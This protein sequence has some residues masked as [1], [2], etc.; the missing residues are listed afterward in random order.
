MSLPDFMSTFEAREAARRMLQLTEETDPSVSL[1]GLVIL[2][3]SWEVDSPVETDVAAVLARLPELVERSQGA[4]HSLLRLRAA[5]VTVAME[6]G[7]SAQVALATLNQACQLSDE[8]FHG[9]WTFRELYVRTQGLLLRSPGIG[10]YLGGAMNNLKRSATDSSVLLQGSTCEVPGPI[11]V[12]A[13]R[14]PGLSASAIVGPTLRLFEP[15]EAG[16][17]LQRM[18][19]EE[20]SPSLKKLLSRMGRESAARA[21]TPVPSLD[22]LDEMAKRFPHFDAVLH[23]VRL[24]LALS[25]LGVPHGSV[26]IPPILLRG[27]PGAGKS[28]FAQELARALGCHYEER[29]L[30]VTSEAFVFTGVDSTWKNAKAGLVFDVLFHGPSANPLIC[31]NEVDKTKTSGSNNSPLASLY[32]LLEPAN[33]R[34]FKDEFIGVSIDASKIVWVLTAND[35]YIPAPVLSRLEVFDIP[36]PNFE[37]SRQIALSV[38][39]DLQKTDFPQGHPFPVELAEDLCSEAARM[40]PRLMR[41]ALMLAAGCAALDGRTTLELKD[42]ALARAAHSKSKQGPLGFLA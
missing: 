33:A 20:T 12:L 9:D 3:T 14:T 36:L 37:Q 15:S 26:R 42:L 29:D 16:M 17:Q 39:S 5:R 8:V 24:S 23:F 19:S 32:S 30:A 21:L 13:L 22:V 18:S 6:R 1:L 25:A 34:R 7:M 40:S 31:L 41:R 2:Y 11:N 4:A 27:E 35:G 38:W 10:A 28:F